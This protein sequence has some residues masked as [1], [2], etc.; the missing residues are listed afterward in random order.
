MAF[1]SSVSLDVDLFWSILSHLNAKFSYKENVLEI[2]VCPA[3][4][5]HS[6]I[7]EI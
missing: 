4:P 6:N 2:I 1:L 5:F 7:F 3:R